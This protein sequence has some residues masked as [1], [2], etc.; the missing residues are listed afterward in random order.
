MPQILPKPYIKVCTISSRGPENKY[1]RLCGPH[2]LCHSLSS[3]KAATE[4]TLKTNKKEAWLFSIK[5]Y[6]QKQAAG[7][8]WPMSCGLLT[9]LWML[10]SCY[11]YY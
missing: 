2:G 10:G 9:L 1:V 3:V 11:S 4:N 7:Q 6:L 8:V 5:L